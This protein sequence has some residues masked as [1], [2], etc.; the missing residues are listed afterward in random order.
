[1][2]PVNVPHDET[3]TA[4]LEFFR[5]RGYE[6]CHTTAYEDEYDKVAIYVREDVPTH[7][8]FQLPNGMWSSKL[9]DW[10]DIEHTLE[11]LVCPWY[12]TVGAVLRKRRP[13]PLPQQ[14]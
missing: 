14:A 6:P 13:G 11:G 5:T 2:W 7:A 1:M 4:F 8:A 3:L 9:G 12:G 10:E